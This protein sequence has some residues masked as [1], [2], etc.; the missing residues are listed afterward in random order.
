MHKT[1][2]AYADVNLR[3]EIQDFMNKLGAEKNE[4]QSVERIHVESNILSFRA[5]VKN[6]VQTTTANEW[7]REGETETKNKLK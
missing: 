5:I 4:R 6:F 2:I 7:G 3:F 1:K